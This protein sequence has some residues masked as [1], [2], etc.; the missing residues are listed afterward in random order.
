VI[1]GSAGLSLLVRLVTGAISLS[2]RAERL[3]VP[4]LPRVVKHAALIAHVG[5]AVRLAA[6]LR[7]PGPFRAE[8][9]VHVLA[10]MASQT[11]ATAIVMG[12][13]S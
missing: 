5:A 6:A 8:A 10:R 7:V 12:L 1:P 11:V 4:P 2:R 13:L 3:P 9:E